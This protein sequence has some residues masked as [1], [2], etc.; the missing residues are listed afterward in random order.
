MA[1]AIVL[2]ACSLFVELGWGADPQ[3]IAAFKASS[4]RTA[5]STSCS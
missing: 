5:A 2:V 1:R 4:S 3:W